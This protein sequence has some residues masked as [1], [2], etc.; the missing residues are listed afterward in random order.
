M[1]VNLSDMCLTSDQPVCDTSRNEVE[2]NVDTC[3]DKVEL[4]ATLDIP[5]LTGTRNDLIDGLEF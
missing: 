4:Y 2:S 5:E 3:H 1:K